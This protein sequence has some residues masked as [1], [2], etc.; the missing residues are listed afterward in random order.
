M[1]LNKDVAAACAKQFCIGC[2][3]PRLQVI[4]ATGKAKFVLRITIG[5][6]MRTPHAFNFRQICLQPLNRARLRGNPLQLSPPIGDLH[7]QHVPI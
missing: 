2:I 3:N 6:L 5:F 7:F 4:A 1:G